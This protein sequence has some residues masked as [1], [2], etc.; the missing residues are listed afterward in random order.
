[1]FSNTGLEVP[2]SMLFL[3]IA[4][5]AFADISFMLSVYQLLRS[6]I[7]RDSGVCILAIQVTQQEEQNSQAV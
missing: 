6:W 4:L 3:Q 5:I 1:M 2:G 7:R